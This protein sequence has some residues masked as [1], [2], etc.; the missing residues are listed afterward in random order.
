MATVSQTYPAPFDAVAEEYDRKF[1]ES[2]IGRAQRASVWKELAKTFRSGDWILEIGCGTGVDASFLANRGVRVFA[3]DNSHA[4]IEVASRRI[5]QADQSSFVHLRTLAAEDLAG[6]GGEPRFD[7]AISN[8]G[9]LNCVEDLRGV[10]IDLA[11]LLRPGATAML[12]LMGRYCAWE[13]AW[14]LAHGDPQKAFRRIGRGKIIARL[15]PEA[16][17]R[18]HYPSV[19]SVIRL[20]SPEFRLKAWKGIGI[21]IPPSYLESIVNRHPWCIRWMMRADSLLES[22]PIARGFADHVLLTFERAMKAG[23]VR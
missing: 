8:F 2:Q 9:A 14:Y 7:G 19:N 17:V 5:A 21:T 20:F 10:A 13:L 12:C 18:V 16:T 4:M 23:D 3:C 1:T 6:L 22:A 11:R 15:A